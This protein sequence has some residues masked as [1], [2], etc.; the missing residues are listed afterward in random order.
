MGKTKNKLTYTCDRCEHI[1]NQ[2]SHYKEHINKKVI[3]GYSDKK[4]EE[5]VKEKMMEEKNKKK[6][7][8]LIE[9]LNIIYD[10]SQKTQTL[11]DKEHKISRKNQ[12]DEQIYQMLD[13]LNELKKLNIDLYLELY[14][15]QKWK[16]FINFYGNKTLKETDLYWNLSDDE[17]EDEKEDDKKYNELKGKIDGVI[18]RCHQILYNNGNIVGRKAM[19]DIMK[20]FT[21]KLFQPMFLDEDSFIYNKTK[22]LRSKDQYILYCQNIT[23][24]AKEDDIMNEWKKLVKNMLCK[25]LPEIYDEKDILFNCDDRTLKEI[26][27]KISKVGDIFYKSENIKKYD[28]ISGDIYEYFVNGYLSGGG[29]ELG[30]FF[31]PRKLIDLTVYA[32]VGNYFT[33][34]NNVDIYDCCMGSGGFLTRTCNI[35]KIKPDNVYGQEIEIDT[36]KFG[37]SNL[38][39]TLKQFPTNIRHCNSI[40]DENHKKHML[41]ITNP[42]FGIKM[43]YVNLKI[44]YEENENKKKKENELYKIIPFENVYPIKTNNGACLF[45][46]HCVYKL[47]QNGMCCVV[48][49]DG[50]LFFGKTF[51]KFRKWLCENVNILSIVKV[52]PGTFEHT[53]IS[54]CVLQFVKKNTTK[55]L[56]FYDTTTNC[57]RLKS[58]MKLS[59]KQLKEENYSFDPKDY[60]QEKQLSKNVEWEKLE[61]LCKIKLGGTPNSKVGIYYGGENSWVQISDMKKNI[62]LETKKK[63]TDIAVKNS[64][65]KLIKKGTI[66]YSFKLSIGKIAYAGKDLYTNEAIA[67]FDITS[68]KILKEYL[69]YLLKYFITHYN[70]TGIIGSGS[71][72][73]EKL[74]N[75]KIPVFSLDIQQKLI[76]NLKFLEQ[77]QI[78]ITKLIR[79]KKL[80]L[81]L[82]KQFGLQSLIN[83]KFKDCE[84]KK[85]G[86]IANFLSTTKHY[87]SIGNKTGKYRFYNSSQNN[88]K[89]LYLD[90]FEVNKRSII[91]GNGGKFNIHI[92]NN[93][94]ASKHVSVFNLKIEDETTLNYIYYYLK[95]KKNDNFRGTSIGWMNKTTMKNIKIPIIN[96]EKQQQLIAIY[97]QKEQQIQQYEQHIQNLKQSLEDI[98]KLGKDIIQS[99][100]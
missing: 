75:I 41:I 10:L 96:K 67:G 91:L 93:F 44:K 33:D 49:P 35:L 71:L 76:E 86:N 15:E 45:V 37:F 4:I 65:V 62:I 97:Q 57:K 42:P 84:F 59:L 40:T 95:Y 17:K 6:A 16:E 48:L 60:I 13:F 51:K 87:T 28:T 66:L 46:Q 8:D 7:Q 88:N 38:L 3:C 56:Q 81:E 69:Y 52:P 98:D 18:K 61:N 83:K 47:K 32:L 43:K 85:L 64:N 31:T 58:M 23:E 19:D 34:M 5:K 92:D 89:K 26:I 74:Q 55:S 63:I 50:E 100:F 99:Y 80:E 70:N 9:H 1:F 20:I 21:L 82:F 14:Q 22:R 30:Q 90:T 39:L 25:I 2:K 94:T 72:N 36:I 77:Q 24:L 54:T 78:D 12:V 11:F 29:K 73:K 27:L 79:N 53:S 68:D